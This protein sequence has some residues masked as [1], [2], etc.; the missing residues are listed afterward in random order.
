MTVIAA[1]ALFMGSSWVGTD[2]EFGIGVLLADRRTS[3]F[4]AVDV[5]NPASLSVGGASGLI[6]GDVRWRHYWMVRGVAETVVRRRI[7]ESLDSES[8]NEKAA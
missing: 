8:R 3:G 2:W 4:G 5:K 1:R 7:L 6:Y